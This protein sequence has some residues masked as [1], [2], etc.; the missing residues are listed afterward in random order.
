MIRLSRGQRQQQSQTDEIF[1]AFGPNPFPLQ[2]EDIQIKERHDPHDRARECGQKVS[3]R[4]KHIDPILPGG[5]AHLKKNPPQGRTRRDNS[6]VGSSFGLRVER[7]VYYAAIPKIKHKF[8]SGGGSEEASDEVVGIIT[9][10][11]P[12]P[13]RPRRINTD[14]HRIPLLPWVS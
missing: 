8:M 9:C 5:R 7:I 12:L 10:T 4:Q 14:S 13:T 2:F 1:N 6:P 11:R 3:R